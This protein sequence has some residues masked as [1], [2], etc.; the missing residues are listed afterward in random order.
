MQPPRAVRHMQNVPSENVERKIALH[1]QNAYAYMR[2]VSKAFDWILTVI[3]FHQEQNKFY[4]TYL[5]FIVIVVICCSEHI[6][7]K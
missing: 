1:C 4:T 3:I 7:S 6:H 2:C 5:G